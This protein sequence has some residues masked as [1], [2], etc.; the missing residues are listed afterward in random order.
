MSSQ[1]TKDFS[2]KSKLRKLADGGSPRPE[3][4]GTG[5]AAQAARNLSGRGRQIDQAVDDATGTAPAPAPAPA[6]VPV[7]A[8]PAPTPKKGLRGFLGLADGGVRPED[9]TGGTATSIFSPAEME[10]FNA[11]GAGAAGSANAS[12]MQA[13]MDGQG[14]A[15]QAAA[16][17]AKS[18]TEFR[19][20]QHGGAVEG[21][22][23][24][25]DDKIGPV[26]LSDE[27]Y[28]LPADTTKAI[29]REKL[30][31]LR[32]AT[33]DF[34][35]DAKESAL[36][37]K[38]K[39]LADGGTWIADDK[40]NVR[41]PN[42]FGDAA[43]GSNYQ[44]PRALPPPQ[45]G[46][47]VGPSNLSPAAG[48]PRTINMGMVEE[49]P[50]QSPLRTPPVEAP[51]G[52]AYQAGKAV[53]GAAGTVGRLAGGVATTAPLAGFG[54]YKADTGG[55]DTSAAGTLGY[56]AKGEFGNV[57]TSLSGGLGEAVADSGRGVAKTADWAAGLVGANP[58]LTG[59]Y[60]RMIQDRLGG[61]LSLR[62]PEIAGPPESAASPAGPSPVQAASSALR[63]DQG[64]ALPVTPGSYQS[65]RLSEMG[66][67]L[68]VQN[69]NPVTDSRA[70]V[71]SGGTS[72]FQNLGTYGGNANVYGR[73]SDPSK[74]GRINDFAGVG[75][76]ASPQNE[77]NGSGWDAALKSALR[78]AGSPAPQQGGGYSNN[79]VEINERYDKMAKNLSGMYGA[80]GQ[81]NL[82]RRLLELEQIRSGALDADARNATSRS[83]TAMQSSTLRDNAQLNARTS[84][85]DTLGRMKQDSATASSQAQAAQL[86]ALQDAQAQ[87]DK[88][89]EDNA[90]VFESVADTFAAGDKD[91]QSQ[92]RELLSTLPP[93]LHDVAQGLA[94][95]DKRAFYTNIVRQQLGRN[96]GLVLGRDAGAVTQ[97]AIA[98]GIVGRMTR[99]GG[100]AGGKA[101][102][103][104][105]G[106]I[107][108]IG[109]VLS[110]LRPVENLSR[111][112]TLI[113]AAGGAL[114]TPK[115]E[116][117]TRWDPVA[118][119]PETGAALPARKDIREAATYG[120]F[121]TY[122]N[123]LGDSVQTVSGRRTNKPTPDEEE[124]ARRLRSA[125]RN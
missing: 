103:R 78:G 38:V 62:N 112:G 110:A 122:A 121:D 19:G 53:A 11:M 71:A 43:A 48:G 9:I 105:L 41:K 26:M 95:E 67:P 77:A 14:A 29:G 52:R 102:D 84:L 107:P 46:T 89:M 23:G 8:A 104:M 91:K 114:A 28:V 124:A 37:Q 59:K 92:Y 94:P 45:T 117:F 24:P 20:F 101:V 7:A 69:S 108:R 60:D 15:A 32:L 111:F 31:A 106:K 6:P 86:K 93:E 50:R 82:A 61:Y 81:G 51:Q 36:R 72:Q 85:I 116:D 25:T 64:A 12:A 123:P 74:P 13:I 66:V 76:G 100:G 97:N 1:M 99:F 98:G 40:G 27:E 2:L 119:D 58:D 42:S 30:D 120:A 10:N 75:A 79:S 17:A 68:D 44:Q 47:A 18:A 90:K 65:R 3:M 5:M 55:V 83:N 16:D 118:R 4:L 70:A 34:K 80:K 33:H 21:P 57:G 22:G 87:S 35:S 56:L 115:V 113:G 88:R 125:L 63:S 39:G 73:A 109:P 49:V 54:D 96:E